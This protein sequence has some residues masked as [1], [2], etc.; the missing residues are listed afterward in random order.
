MLGVYLPVVLQ[1]V[2]KTNFS[3]AP[4]DYQSGLGRV[5]SEDDFWAWAASMGQPRPADKTTV[6]KGVP[7]DMVIAARYRLPRFDFMKRWGMTWA[8]TLQVAITTARPA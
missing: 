1:T 5:Y 7:A 2:I 3:W 4:G 6:N 8:S